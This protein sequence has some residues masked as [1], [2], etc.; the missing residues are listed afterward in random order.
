MASI[1][2]S[3]GSEPPLPRFSRDWAVG[4]VCCGRGQVVEYPAPAPSIGSVVITPASMAASLSSAFVATRQI[5]PRHQQYDRLRQSSERPLVLP[6]SFD[7]I[8]HQLHKVVDIVALDPTDHGH[9][10]RGRDPPR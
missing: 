9:E 2:V 7:G 1:T 5:L 3:W 8:E 10:F 4:A 6:A